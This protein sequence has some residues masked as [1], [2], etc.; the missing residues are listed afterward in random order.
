MH[1]TNYISQPES[2]N[3]HTFWSL[4]VDTKTMVTFTLAVNQN[5]KPKL[6]LCTYI[7]CNLNFYSPALIFHDL[8]HHML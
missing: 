2:N 4:M 1:Q 5:Y 6:F 8:L 3:E 7:S